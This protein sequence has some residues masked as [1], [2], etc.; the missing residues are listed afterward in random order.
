MRHYLHSSSPK[1]IKKSFDVLSAPFPVA[2]PKGNGAGIRPQFDLR[3]FKAS[4]QYLSPRILPLSM[5][6][7]ADLNMS[8]AFLRASSLP[9]TQSC[10]LKA[11]TDGMGGG[12]VTIVAVRVEGG[13]EDVGNVCVAVLEEMSRV[14][15]SLACDI[16]PRAVL[17][18]SVRLRSSI[19]LGCSLKLW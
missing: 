1:E 4:T 9:P 15:K 3:I 13:C 6:S 10:A 7:A 5:L 11:S 12:L 19:T 18:Y 8:A 16:S 17:V 14:N 2:D